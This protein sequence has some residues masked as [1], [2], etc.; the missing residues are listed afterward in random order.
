MAHLKTNKVHV[1]TWA[2]L[3]LGIVLKMAERPNEI[4]YYELP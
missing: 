2:L 4:V 1:W 3:G